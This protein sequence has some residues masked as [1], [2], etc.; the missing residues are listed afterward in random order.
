MVL[1]KLGDE[2][3]KSRVV[4]RRGRDEVPVCGQMQSVLAPGAP[5]GKGFEEEAQHLAVPGGDQAS[6]VCGRSLVGELDVC[7]EFEPCL[8]VVVNRALPERLQSRAWIVPQ[9]I[10]AIGS[11]EVDMFA[12]QRKNRVH[13]PL[14]VHRNRY[15]HVLESVFVLP[16]DCED[17]AEVFVVMLPEYPVFDSL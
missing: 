3:E 9:N 2:G 14:M 13:K 7:V 8:A 15:H 17:S 12:G 6:V 5:F 1:E 10:D 4:G 16:F 11:L